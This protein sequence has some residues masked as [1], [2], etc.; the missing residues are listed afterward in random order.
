MTDKP[1][2]P[3][4]VEAGRNEFLSGTMEVVCGPVT[5]TF[6]SSSLHSSSIMGSLTTEPQMKSELTLNMTSRQAVSEIQGHRFKH[7]GKKSVGAICLLQGCQEG[8]AELVSRL[9]GYGGAY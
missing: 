8:S 5:P 3:V 1:K 9:D 4:A 7:W 2:K 6:L